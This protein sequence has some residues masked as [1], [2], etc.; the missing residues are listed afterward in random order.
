[1]IKYRIHPYPN[2]PILYFWQ[3]ANIPQYSASSG[4][5]CLPVERIVRS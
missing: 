3:N 4:L 2:M 5:H 1:M